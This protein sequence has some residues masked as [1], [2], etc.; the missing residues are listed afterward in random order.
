MSLLSRITASFRGNGRI[1]AAPAGLNPANPG[2]P[3]LGRITLPAISTSTQFNLYQNPS[4]VQIKQV[5]ELGLGGDLAGQWAL[6]SQMQDTW[7]RLRKCLHEL[8][9]AV[10]R[11]PWR[12][13]PASEERTPPT[14]KA[15]R[16]AALARESFLNWS[17]APGSDE[18]GFEDCVYDLTDALACGIS[19]Q[20]ILWE[21][22][23]QVLRPR[24]SVWVNPRYY[25]LMPDGRIGL[26]VD[27]EPPLTS[28]PAFQPLPLDKFLVA[29]HR[30]GTGGLSAQALLRPLAWWWG[31]ALWGRDWIL[32]YAQVY[33]QPIRWVT[34]D[35]SCDPATLSLLDQMMEQL[36]SSGWGRFP[37][38]TSLDLKESAQTSGANP[39]ERV[40]AM[41][42]KACDLLVLGE[43]LTSD[44]GDSGSLALGKVHET[45]RDERKTALAKWAAD[46]INYQLLPA[47]TRL[48]FGT[49]DECP[50]LTINDT[51]KPDL[52][53]LAVR[54]ETLMRAGLP[55]PRVWAHQQLGIPI[56][57]EGAA[58]LETKAPAPLPV[59]P[60][61]FGKAEEA[62]EDRLALKASH[63]QT[64]RNGTHF[65]A[66]SP[67]PTRPRDIPAEIAAQKSAALAQVFRG[68]MAPIRGLV[69]ESTS[70]AD[71]EAKLRAYYED[72]PAAPIA[73]V[74][75]E[76]LQVMAA[77][78]AADAVQ[79]HQA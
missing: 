79:N 9:S 30:S 46:V 29:T 51:S 6:F 69:E 64:A 18:N 35:P 73:D 78:G 32:N 45:V 50:I 33:G 11:A 77:A 48:N 59:A 72:F 67:A 38:G 41:A 60:G 43:T 56:P 7:P 62:P 34:H 36:G 44:V 68:A 12:I 23:G 61:A 66:S 63:D 74:M 37:A 49:D 21:Q 24:A 40:L 14:P 27:R 3:V 53:K 71:L 25:G 15:V 54:L 42:D 16:R 52:D 58:V 13:L 55:I 31:A 28:A 20:E 76:A 4:P 8:R 70:A 5:L 22:K 39:Q 47:F 65:T 17:P 57:K 26:R 19:V 1:T 10:A 75:E 2:R